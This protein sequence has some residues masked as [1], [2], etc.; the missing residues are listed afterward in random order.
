[1]RPNEKYIGCRVDSFSSPPQ[2]KFIQRRATTDDE[3]RE[4]EMQKLRRDY[5]S[6]EN[7]TLSANITGKIINYC[8]LFIGGACLS[9]I[10][11][12][13]SR[14]CNLVNLTTARQRRRVDG[15]KY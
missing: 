5:R 10:S 12:V 11:V 9:I 7:T 15:E 13:Q 6:G 3:L 4:L 2:C 14:D 8:Q 1:M